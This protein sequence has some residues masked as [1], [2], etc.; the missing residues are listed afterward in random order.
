MTSRERV[1]AAI[2]GQSID[3]VPVM[4]W[5]NPHA[6]CR[7]MA[8]HQPGHSRAINML[9]RLLWK[10]FTRGGEFDAGAWTRAAPL[11]LEEYGNGRYVLE[12]GADV[13]ILS[14][15]LI[16]PTSFIGSVR[17][18][19]G[20][21]RVRA[22]F[23]VGMALGGIYMDP[24][25]PAVKRIED[26]ADLQLPA[27]APPGFKPP[28]SPGHS[29]TPSHQQRANGSMVCSSDF[30]QCPVSK[31]SSPCVSCLTICAQADAA[32]GGAA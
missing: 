10:R 22:P 24:V 15:E 21:L 4:Y 27:C 14:P 18:D 3:R 29:R 11:L 26:L 8:E 17:R 28:P 13:A 5:L 12:L 16:S 6:T 7:L 19:N 20:R 2:K 31:C 9:A 32:F 23:G 30:R 25:E 1:L